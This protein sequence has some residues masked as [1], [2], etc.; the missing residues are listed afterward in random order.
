M[1]DIK[2][3]IPFIRW[4]ALLVGGILLLIGLT[5]YIRSYHDKIRVNF[6]QRYCDNLNHDIKLLSEKWKA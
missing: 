5:S 3:I 4:P 2:Q 6:L 1:D